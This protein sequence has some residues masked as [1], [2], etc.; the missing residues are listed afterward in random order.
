MRDKS[1]VK[2]FGCGGYRHFAAECRKNRKGKEQ[3]Q[4]VNISQAEE[5]EPA[6]LMVKNNSS[7]DC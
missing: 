4:E 6:L 1:K 2:C 5:D 3:R 7:K